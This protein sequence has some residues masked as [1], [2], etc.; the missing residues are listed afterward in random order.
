M[1]SLLDYSCHDLRVQKQSLSDDKHLTTM[2]DDQQL[3]IKQ[4]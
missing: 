1:Q 2:N 3:D 4:V